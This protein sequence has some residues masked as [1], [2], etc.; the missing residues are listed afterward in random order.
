MIRVGLILGVTLGL[1][2][3]S[4]CFSIHIGAQP[5]ERDLLAQPAMQ[6]DELY[7]SIDDHIYYSKEASSGGRSYGGGGCG[8]N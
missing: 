8:C 2:L 6:Y 7:E 4:S 1:A 5:W 3:L